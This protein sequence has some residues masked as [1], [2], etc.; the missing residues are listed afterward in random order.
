MQ[1]AS[2]TGVLRVLLIFFAVY[3]GIKILMRLLSPFLI[4]YMSQKF[5]KK[6]R[7]RYE[8]QT[9]NQPPTPPKKENKPKDDTLGE[10]ID[11]EE[12]D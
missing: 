1:L 8:H 3:Y 9:G 12:I 11:Y 6:M 2:L 4:K 5:E 10:Y 7:E